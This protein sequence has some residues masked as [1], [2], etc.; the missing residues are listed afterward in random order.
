MAVQYRPLKGDVTCIQLSGKC[1][2]W[3]KYC[4]LDYS[5]LMF[6]SLL[7]MKV[8][9]PCFTCSDFV[10]TFFLISLAMVKWN[11]SMLCTL[12]DT[13]L[14]ERF[15]V[16]FYSRTTALKIICTLLIPH[17]S[18]LLFTKCV[19]SIFSRKL[20]QAAII[21][22]THTKWAVIQSD[23]VVAKYNR[24]LLYSLIVLMCC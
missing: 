20:A 16:I 17:C 6:A 2:K 18:L 3:L 4:L 13:L 7:V 24:L 1:Q 11:V 23:S 15:T 22:N 9:N 5:C 10:W 8:M 19:H 12:G 14:C 21:L